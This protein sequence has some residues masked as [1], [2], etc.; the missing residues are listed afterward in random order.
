MAFIS[1]PF[2]GL[3]MDVK[4]VP[5]LS[6][7]SQELRQDTHLPWVPLVGGSV[8][9]G[10]V[11]VSE[12]EALLRSADAATH[13]ARRR[14]RRGVVKT[15]RAYSQVSSSQGIP[16]GITMSTVVVD[17][18]MWDVDFDVDVDSDDGD[19]SD[20]AESRNYDSD[21]SW[22]SIAMIVAEFRQQ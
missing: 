4:D 12:S 17:M 13:D 9:L 19:N 1:L 21:S 11:G 3:A 16:N 20:R 15:I 22:N 18:W 2:T 14:Q 5:K 8:Y 6:P 7:A 10:V